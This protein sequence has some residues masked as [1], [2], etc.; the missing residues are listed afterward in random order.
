MVVKAN[1]WTE[2][3]RI[4]V[5]GGMAMVVAMSAIVFLFIQF[6]IV[7]DRFH[8]SDLWKSEISGFAVARTVLP[9]LYVVTIVP[10]AIVGS[11]A[12]SRMKRNAFK[13]KNILLLLALPGEGFL[14]AAVLLSLFD[15]VLSKSSLLLQIA[16]IVTS[17]SVSMVVIAFTTR[18]KRVHE[19]IKKN[20]D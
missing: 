11:V 16:L 15:A 10:A 17:C 14:L 3:E 18:L 6:V 1:K 19:Y 9:F 4:M 7:E 2:R 5:Y 12:Y 20:F 13:I 8:L